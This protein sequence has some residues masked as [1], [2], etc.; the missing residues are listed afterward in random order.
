[1]RELKFRAW[2]TDDSYLSDKQTPFME[3]D[4]AFEEYMSI[5]DEL[6]ASQSSGNKIMQYTGL[7]D[8]NGKEIYEGDIVEAW[9][10]G[11]R[12]VGSVSKR[13]DGLWFMYPSYQKD[14]MWFLSPDESGH[15]YVNIIGNIYENPELLEE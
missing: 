10:E 3:E 7:K 12:G 8:K 13:I 9:S 6:S 5:N 14:R 4:F 1:M 15:D 2:I 11:V